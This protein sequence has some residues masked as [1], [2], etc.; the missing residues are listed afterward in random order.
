MLHPSE[1]QIYVDAA[2]GVAQSVVS[3]LHTRFGLYGYAAYTPRSDPQGIITSWQD[4]YVT[5]NAQ[6]RPSVT[7]NPLRESLRA[8]AGET[9]C[10]QTA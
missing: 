9:V 4:V 3:G 10:T 2:F 8:A 6:R 5:G 7:N 1:R